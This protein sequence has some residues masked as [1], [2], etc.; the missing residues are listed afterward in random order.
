M[1]AE[2]AMDAV[3]ALVADLDV[4]DGS[5][6]N[7]A[8]HT[9]A[10]KAAETSQPEADN[11]SRW[12][13]GKAA[14]AD[15]VAVTVYSRDGKRLAAVAASEQQA[16]SK[17]A[18][19]AKTGK[20]AAPEGTAHSP[21][22]SRP[23]RQRGKA[24][25]YWM[26]GATAPASSPV[27]KAAQ[28]DPAS[29]HAMLPCH[30]G[31]LLLPE[32]PQGNIAKAGKPGKTKKAAGPKRQN[33]TSPHKEQQ[34]QQPVKRSRTAAKQQQEQQQLQHEAAWED[35]A[36]AEA[37]EG[38]VAEAVQMAEQPADSRGGAETQ[39]AGSLGG[40]QAAGIEHQD[41]ED[42]A[43]EEA[44]MVKTKGMVQEQDAVSPDVAVALRTKCAA[45]A[46]HHP[47]LTNHAP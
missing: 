12:G 37:A 43:A 14:E 35:A 6:Q 9:A 16:K 13:T 3:S 19:G 17:P 8:R 23:A 24:Q 11:K 32:Q 21:S 5:L 30:E 27:P 46:A 34:Q 38:G 25:P 1:Q 47:E 15:K 10:H 42:A 4:T 28:A 2:Q 40:A 7:T 44:G 22:D 18:A 26:G 31:H 33:R 39:E 29:S 20:A 41:R 36:E 45:C